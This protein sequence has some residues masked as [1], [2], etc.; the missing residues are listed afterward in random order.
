KVRGAGSSTIIIRPAPKLH[1]V[2]YKVMPDRIVTGTMLVAAAMTNGELTLENTRPEQVAIVISK[3][4]DAGCAIRTEDD[5][6]HIRGT[7]R[8]QAVRS[9]ETLPYPGFPTDMQAQMMALQT[10]SEGTSIIVENVFENRFKHAVE[11]RKMGADITIKDRTAI[12]H[13]VKDL[14]G[15][16]VTAYDLR[17]GA[18]LVLAALRA[19]GISKI[20]SVYHIDRGYY[21]FEEVLSGLGADIMRV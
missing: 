13:G 3:L 14:Y 17:G 18:A 10:V 1:G 4:R 15:T 2:E 11:L 21:N 8:P 6:I 16:E 5:T 7:K 19:K 12:V 9:I 20:N